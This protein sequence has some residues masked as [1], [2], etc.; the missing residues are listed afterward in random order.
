[1]VGIHLTVHRE[2]ERAWSVWESTWRSLRCVGW[3]TSEEAARAVV[4][5]LS[6]EDA[7]ATWR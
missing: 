2:G 7:R 1:M 4:R 5:L 6:S 3:C